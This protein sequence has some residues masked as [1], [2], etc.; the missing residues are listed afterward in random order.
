MLFL[1]FFLFL[2]TDMLYLYIRTY[3]NANLYAR[4]QPWPLIINYENKIPNCTGES[5]YIF[6]MQHWIHSGWVYNIQ[7][8]S[9][10]WNSF[11]CFFD[12]S[13]IHFFLLLHL[14]ITTRQKI[15]FTFQN[16]SNQ[17]ENKPMETNPLMRT[18][19][20]SQKKKN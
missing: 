7:K 12:L 5:Q 11:Y 16:E 1:F 2:Q 4:K 9:H 19:F 17:T 6:L 15:R 3:V 18:K 13:N 8:I 20:F 10:F 14:V